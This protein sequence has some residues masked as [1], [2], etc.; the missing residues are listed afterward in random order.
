L[1]TQKGNIEWV[2]EK[3][4]PCFQRHFNDLGERTP[5]ELAARDEMTRQLNEQAL[6]TEGE[7]ILSY[8]KP[9]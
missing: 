6:E 9:Q 4:T 3:C 2:A 7:V 8:H 1:G 5:E